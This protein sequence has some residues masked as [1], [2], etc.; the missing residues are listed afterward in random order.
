MKKVLIAGTTGY[1][2]KFVAAEFKKQHFFT[3]IIARDIARFQCEN[4]Q[5]D[6]LIKAEVTDPETL[7]TCC[8]GIDIVFS[9]IGIT[10]QKDGLTYMDVDFQANLNLLHI[11]QIL[12]S[13][14][15]KKDL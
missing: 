12:K 5:A 4:I 11:L 9:S 14:Q 2:G 15:Q 10:K 3:R 6:E 1:I 7:V 13:A 8:D